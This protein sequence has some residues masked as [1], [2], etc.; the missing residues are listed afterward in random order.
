MKQVIHLLSQFLP[1]CPLFRTRI[2]LRFIWNI[3]DGLRPVTPRRTMRVSY[4][5][6][7]DAIHKGKEGSTLV[8]VA[9]Q[10]REHRETHLLGYIVR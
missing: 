8:A 10:S 9:W 7:G 4:L 3:G 5:V 6:R 1:Q 2:R